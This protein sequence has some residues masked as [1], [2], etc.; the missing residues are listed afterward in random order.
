MGDDPLR[1][2]RDGALRDRERIEAEPPGGFAKSGRV[3]ERGEGRKA[4][5]LA[6]RESAIRDGALHESDDLA[7]IRAAAKADAGDDHG[8]TTTHCV[9]GIAAR[10]PCR[11]PTRSS[12]ERAMRRMAPP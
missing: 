2:L 9:T 6:A 11:V 4:A 3:G 12:R 1:R 7:W 10:Q 5:Q 8:F